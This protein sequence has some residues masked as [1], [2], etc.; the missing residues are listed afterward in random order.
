MAGCSLNRT[1]MEL[2]RNLGRVVLDGVLG[3]N[4]TFMEL[5]LLNHR[6]KTALLPS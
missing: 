5:K 6:S 2:K 3:L 4:R 1:F